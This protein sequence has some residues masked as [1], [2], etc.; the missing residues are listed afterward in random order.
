MAVDITYDTDTGEMVPHTERGEALLTG[1]LKTMATATD[2]PRLLDDETMNDL[3]LPI[4]KLDG[5]VADKLALAF[6]GSVALD[7]LMNDDLAMIEGFALGRKITLTIEATIAGKGF[8]HTEKAAT[9]TKD[10]E[11]V[12]TYQVKLRVHSIIGSQVDE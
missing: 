6:G 10:E 3:Q 5:H 9:E 4:P 1:G 11:E 12:V 7:R 8:T 2:D